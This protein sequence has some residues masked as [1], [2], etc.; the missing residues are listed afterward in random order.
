[1][2]GCNQLFDLNS[3]YNAQIYKTICVD[4]RFDRDSISNIR[5][6]FERWSIS[7]GT[8]Y[9]MITFKVVFDIS[10]R[11]DSKKQTNFCDI[12]VLKK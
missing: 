11:F 9:V 4:N 8:N 10:G 12:Y 3:P 7:T 5:D 2:S 1:M 6:I